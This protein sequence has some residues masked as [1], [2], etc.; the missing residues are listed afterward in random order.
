MRRAESGYYLRTRNQLFF[1]F[2]NYLN[3]R[4]Y[5]TQGHSTHSRGVWGERA[6]VPPT[7]SDQ[8]GPLEDTDECTVELASSGRSFS[9]GD[10]T[11][12]EVV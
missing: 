2:S 9:S 4:S 5:N 11:E 1:C 8:I 3:V 12:P 7:H 6:S 10:F